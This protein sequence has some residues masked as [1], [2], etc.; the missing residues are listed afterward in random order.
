MPPSNITGISR[1]GS[2]IQV[3]IGHS[4]SGIGASTG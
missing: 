1:A 4:R 2:A 3:I